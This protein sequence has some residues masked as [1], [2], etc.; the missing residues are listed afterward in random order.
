[1]VVLVMQV[2]RNKRRLA[3]SQH[4]GSGAT[5]VVDQATRAMT[6]VF[7]SNLLMG[8]PHS[9]FHLLE[10][11]SLTLD[12]IFH[13]LFYTHFIVDPVVF[14]WYNRD[15]HQRVGERLRA[16]LELMKQYCRLSKTISTFHLH[17]PST[18][19]TNQASSENEHGGSDNMC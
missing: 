13:G 8:I 7:V 17:S 19:S 15:Y 16:G 2:R 6:A 12:I 1:M 14:I 5:S 4:E 11:P 18:S 10:N 3:G 9:V